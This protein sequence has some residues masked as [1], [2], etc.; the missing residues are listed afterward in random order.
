M[1]VMGLFIQ[2]TNNKYAHQNTI[3]YTAYASNDEKN[4]FNFIKS[5]E[6]IMDFIYDGSILLYGGALLIIIS[7]LGMFF[8]LKPRKNK[9]KKRKK[10]IKHR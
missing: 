5:E 7:L 2:N 10:D 4:N 3:F 8:S 6:N 1:I 9:H